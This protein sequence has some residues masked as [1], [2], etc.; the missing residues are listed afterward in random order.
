MALD[1]QGNNGV[2]IQTKPNTKIPFDL[3]ANIPQILTGADLEGYFLPANSNYTGITENEVN[4]TGLPTGDYDLCFQLFFADGSPATDAESGCAMFTVELAVVNINTM[5]Q[6]PYEN[7]WIDWYDQTTVKVTSTRNLE[8]VYMMLGLQGNN[9]VSIRTT[10]NTRLPFDLEANIPQILTGVDLEDYFL[11]ANSTFTGITESEANN[12]GLPVGDYNLCFQ[13]FYAD[14]T[15]ATNPEDGCAMFSI[16]LPIVTLS[17]IVIP[18]YNNPI[19]DWPDQTTVYIQSNRSIS[20]AL[21]SFSLIGDNGI[22]INS[23]AG[24]Y[25]SVELE[26]NVPLML[27]GID[28]SAILDIG[29]LNIAGI[30]TTELSETGLPIG[31]Y[32]YCFRLWYDNNTPLTGDAPAGCFN[33]EILPATLMLTTNVIPPY[34]H[35]MDR[36]PEITQVNILST[37]AQDILLKR[38]SKETMGLSLEIRKPYR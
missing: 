6:P 3:E 37:S 8:A 2:R 21:L 31:S 9:G 17:T 32:Q 5:V 22:T 15:P 24:Q 33:M 13:L 34:S 18:P 4:S 25:T 7:P 36:I 19:E 12:F 1:L 26:A 20:N 23:I 28:L 27:T 14:G 10:S 30:T 11:P 29:V 35:L 38:V 16:D